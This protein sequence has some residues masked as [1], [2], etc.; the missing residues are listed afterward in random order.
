MPEAVRIAAPPLSPAEA[1]LAPHPGV[2]RTA[3]AASADLRVAVHAAGSLPPGLVA[4]W[5]ELAALA[6]EPNSY[7]E[8][9]FVTASTE[10]LG[11]PE[12]LRF[13][14]VRRGPELLGL[15]PLAI[16]RRYGRT[17][18]PFV[19]NWRHHHHFLGTPLVRRGEVEV[20]WPAV[21]RTLD[22][23][24]WAPHFLY[25]RGLVEDGPVHRGLVAAAAALGR[26]CPLVHRE[27]RA[28]LEGVGD[29]QAYYRD[30]IRP[31][32]RKELRRLRHRLDE[33]GE[34]RVR[35][36]AADESPDS[37]CDAFL[38][39]EAAGWKGEEGSALAC[40]PATDAFFRKTVA[41]A[42][43]A[44]KLQ[45]VRLDL[46][47]RAIA[48]LV[49]FLAPPGGFSFKTAFD[50]A[51]A[52]FS[53]GVLIQLENLRLVEQAGLAWMDSCAAENH[54]MID[55]LWTGRRRIVRV[56]VRLA[57]FRRGLV[58]AACRALEA[59]SA[60]LRRLARGSQA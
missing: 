45:F 20:F 49:N 19:Q 21:L 41:A 42:H 59:G 8:P 24:D 37:W 12:T 36:L 29:A 9:W 30:S 39:L 28:L 57:G 17:R 25:V 4:D 7:A 52:R 27:S 47:G 40:D 2:V 14:E 38:A 1:P 53:P 23:A 5:A 54:P 48:M 16:G 26:G 35:T 22:S 15:I 60:A 13:V 55:S 6:A 33:L 56:T 34:V 10:T 44:G 58:F 51:Y 31:K 11:A 46:D 3:Q 50:P 43:A 32:K 18:V